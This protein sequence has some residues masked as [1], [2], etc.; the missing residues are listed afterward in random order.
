YVGAN[1]E[2]HD[3]DDPLAKVA[4]TKWGVKIQGEV[5]APLAERW[6][7][8]FL[9]TYSTAFNSYFTIGKL[10]YKIAP[11]IAIGPEVI[12]LGNDRFDAVRTGPFIAFDI[13]AET[14]L[15]FS[16]GYTWDTR[17]DAFNNHS[18]EYFTAHFR[19]NF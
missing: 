10:G 13:Y 15:I 18:G 16:G 8:L 11:V 6:Y 2:H 4:G 1:V 7:A 12:A 3:N 17:K 9:G 19:T 14:Q 5:Y